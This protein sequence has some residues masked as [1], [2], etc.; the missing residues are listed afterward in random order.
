VSVVDEAHGEPV[1]VAAGP[2]PRPTAAAH[3]V[4]A[5]PPFEEYYL[6]Y[7]D[8]TAACAPEFLT[9]IGPSMNGI[10]RPILLARGEVV[11]VWSHSLAVGRHADAPVPE[12]FARHTATDAEIGAALDRYRAFIAG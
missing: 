12:L 8:R 2:A 4:V 10:V 9:R 3:E 6:S 7:A 11:G 5:L 1:Y